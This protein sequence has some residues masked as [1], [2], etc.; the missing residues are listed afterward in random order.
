MTVV[1]NTV[2]DPGGRALPRTRVTIQLIAAAT[3]VGP[4][5]VGA[6]DV[7]VIDTWELQTDAAGAWTASLTDNASIT[8]AGTVYRVTE[9][10]PGGRPHTYTI[11]VPTGA[12]RWVGDIL[13]D[14]PATLATAALQAHLDDTLDAHDAT[15]ISYAGGTGLVATTVEAALD[16]L[17]NE[18]LDITTAS[19]T[20]A[21]VSGGALSVNGVALSESVYPA[22][23]A[24]DAEVAATY[25]ALVGGIIGING[26]ALTETAYP[27]TLARDTE[28]AAG[29]VAQAFAATG[30][31]DTTALQALLTAGS[32]RL[33]PGQTYL[34]TALTVAANTVLDLNGSTIKKHS[35]VSNLVTAGSGSI[36]RDGFLD[37][38]ALAGSLYRNSTTDAKAI[39]LK[40]TN[41]PTTAYDITAATRATLINC[42]SVGAYYGVLVNTGSIDTL[43]LG[44]SHTGGIATTSFEGSLYLPNSIR[45][46]VI[47]LTV[48]GSAGHGAWIGGAFSTDTTL[49][50][51]RFRANGTSGDHRGCTVDATIAR[52]LL[53]D[54][55]FES[56]YEA[57]CYVSGTPTHVRLVSCTARG[58]N[59]GLR[60]GGHGIEHLG[61]GGGVYD[62]LAI[63]QLGDAANEGVG[64]YIGS[65][66]ANAIGNI[67]ESNYSAGIRVVDADNAIISG[68]RCR[69]NGQRGV[70][71]HD[72]IELSGLSA[73]SLLDVQ[74]I[75][76]RCYDD[77]GTKTQR[78]GIAVNA[79]CDW[80]TLVDNNTRGNATGGISDTGGANKIV[81][82]N[83]AP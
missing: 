20:Y 35:G 3:G 72:G 1:N 9:L 77:Q 52:V 67:V 41:L 59:V 56:N 70:G 50:G 32:V 28:V 71:L 46:T 58:N 65:N 43:I 78:Y 21:A 8:P 5:F 26:A 27:S 53:Q 36:V 76:N 39:N 18:K 62:C 7:T 68:N 14:P 15:A 13:V 51:C 47:G 48:S 37:G 34:V 24:R 33:R 29:Y 64:I 31:N 45:T 57:G 23:L 49:I 4:G 79:N 30:G 40:A 61:L 63:G 17:A 60:P 16:E 10:P 38:N 44:G 80:Y 42:D 19:G 12:A 11:S 55:T 74:V 81:A 69:N 66:G 83:L 54:C 2:T 25:A 75:G 73:A 6:T 22:A 82:N